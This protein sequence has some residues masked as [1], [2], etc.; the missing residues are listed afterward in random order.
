MPDS[1]RFDHYEVLTRDDGSLFEL[2]RGAMGIT[3]KAMDSN[4]R[5]PVCL[6]VIAT[7][8]LHS[9][10]ARQRFI[11]EAR[12][13]ARLRNPHVAAVYHLGTEGD[14][15]YYAMEFIDGETVDGLIRRNGPLAPKL[16]LRITDQ[17]ATA[18]LA[19]EP[20]GLVHRDIKPANLMVIRDG[21]NLTVKV[22]DFGLAKSSLPDEQ[23]ATLSQGGF[24]GT[25]HFAS[26][27]QLEERDLDV[28]SDI[29]SVG[30]T[31]WFMLAGRTPFAGSMAQVMSAHLSRTPP[32]E[33]LN[34][35]AP[36]ARLLRRMLEKDAANRPQ[37]SAELRREIA[38]CLAELESPDAA[39]MP[40]EAVAGRDV[41]EDFHTIADVWDLAVQMKFEPG[42][43]VAGRYRIKADLGDSNLGRVFHAHDQTRACDV[44]IVTL[45]R[46]LTEGAETL[47]AL[48]QM[49]DKL[50]PRPHSA[51]QRVEALETVGDT[52]FLVMEWF[53]GA[54]LVEVLRARREI[55]PA[56]VHSLLAPAAAGIDHVLA[57]GIEEVEMA[58]H[59]VLIAFGAE[60][61]EGWLRQPVAEWPPHAIK[62]KP[63]SVR[64]A[65][66][67]GGTWVEEQTVIDSAP[68]TRTGGGAAQR[69]VRSLAMVVY[70][71]LG[72][73]IS[74]SALGGRRPDFKPLSALDEAGN[75]ILRRALGDD[76]PFRSVATFIGALAAPES[77]DLP[78]PTTHTTNSTK[79]ANRRTGDASPDAASAQRPQSSSVVRVLVVALVLVLGG[80]VFVWFKSRPQPL[81]RSTNDSSTVEPN[82]T[83]SVPD[84]NPAPKEPPVPTRQDMLAARVGEAKKL[85]SEKKIPECLAAWIA[86]TRDF[87]ESDA[88]KSNL[89]NLCFTMRSRPDGLS[90]EV[91]AT[92][93]PVLTEAAQLEVISAMMVLGENLRR[94]VPGEAFQRYNRAGEL[95]DLEGKVQAGLM[96]SN[97]LGVEPDLEKAVAIFKDA[98]AKGHQSAKTALGD[99]LLHGK[100]VP[101]DVPAGIALLR[102]ASDASDKR[103]KDLL[104]DA[105]V[106]GLAPTLDREEP[107]RLYEQAAELG[108]KSAYG[109]LGILYFN[110]T[111][112]APMDPRQ[113]FVSIKTGAEASDPYCM[114]LFAKCYESG[115]G[116]PVNL[117]IARTWYQKAAA[118]GSAAAKAWCERN[119][120]PPLPE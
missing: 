109:N 103:A 104:A 85:E 35:P 88:G 16:A 34:V 22:I 107:K 6:K 76:P 54:S 120:V 115:T 27:E 40:S 118:A 1:V 37:N 92:L 25:P 110:G 46:S 62:I 77:A 47:G 17:V 14:A 56:E 99:C 102:E 20:H 91:F 101:K 4:L 33:K 98:A 63:L 75:E 100:G 10:L 38:Q 78:R 106:K 116:V 23:G 89:E 51:V 60:P 61:P 29:Y 119:N 65:A 86:I 90:P 84:E 64:A 43:V 68:G 80:I 12:S 114:F 79:V 70:E 111:G 71:L 81:A 74:H 108:L 93:R 69:A 55:T 82:I 9:E 2:G 73:K 45:H 57:S 19:A 67:A 49:V 50:A 32:F 44:R 58:L 72:G 59:Q 48:E 97:G 8:H 28:R 113:G 26:P 5:I 18:L 42:E 21:E 112:G 87:P 94:S 11:R 36:L 95:G 66:A 30:V 53:P 3:Y 52:T 105:L 13:A 24:V 39:V 117:Q 7:A 83:P 15:Y 41:Q 31:L 96:L